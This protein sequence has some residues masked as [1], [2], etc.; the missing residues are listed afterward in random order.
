[1]TCANRLRPVNFELILEVFDAFDLQQRFLGHLLLLVRADPSAND[2]VPGPVLDTQPP[3]G[4]I[5]IR[6]KC[7]FKIVQQ[8]VFTDGHRLIPRIAWERDRSARNVREQSRYRPRRWAS[9]SLTITEA[10]TKRESVSKP[11][12]VPVVRRQ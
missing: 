10:V 1:M 9:W 6:D 3:S 12:V 11:T 8:N 4:D 7:G 5:R 2:H